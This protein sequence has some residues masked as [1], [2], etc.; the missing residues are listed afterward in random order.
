MEI[1]KKR[2]ERNETQSW[3]NDPLVLE[4]L[5]NSQKDRLFDWKQRIEFWGIVLDE[6]ENPIKD[7]NVRFGWTDLSATGSSEFNVHSDQDGRFE[8]ANRT[9]KRLTVRVQKPGYHDCGEGSISF[10]FAD[11]SDAAFH[12]P[13]LNRPVVFRLIRMGSP[14]PVVHRDRIQEYRAPDAS[15]IVAFDLLGQREVPAGD[16]AADLVIQANHGPVRGEGMERWFDWRVELSVPNGGIQLGTECPPFAPEE[17]YQRNLVFDGK[18][19]GRNT[20]SGIDN[21][22]FLKCR[23]GDHY[24]RVHLKVAALPY[25]GGNAKVSLLEYTVNPAGSRN[26]EVYPELQVNEKYYVPRNRIPPP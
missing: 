19:E 12:R 17:G 4:Y 15:G 20:L 18:V 3:T 11:P 14:E 9:G 16:P 21:W 22:F 8:L 25:G 2:L 13:D 7:A 23:G 1:Q 6:T 10:E 5:R 26:L 24:A